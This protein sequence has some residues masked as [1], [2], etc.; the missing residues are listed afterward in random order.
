MT[1]VSSGLA[2]QLAA[3]KIAIT[4]S[5]IKQSFDNQKA[6][7]NIIDQAARNIQAST[8]RGTNVNRSA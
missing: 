4:T 7:A 8:T 5:V 2:Q 3:T 6:V 1:E